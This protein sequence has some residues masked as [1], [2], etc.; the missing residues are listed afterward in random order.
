VVGSGKTGSQDFDA[1]GRNKEGL[2]REETPKGEKKSA[3]KTQRETRED[4]DNMITNGERRSGD[5]RNV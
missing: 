5:A 1:V 2:R 3:G 4:K